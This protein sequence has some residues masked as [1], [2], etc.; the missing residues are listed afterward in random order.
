MDPP[1]MVLVPAELIS[2]ALVNLESVDLVEVDL[3]PEQKITFFKEILKT[4]VM[5]LK[6]L[7]SSFD[8]ATP[9]FI[10]AIVRVENVN[11]TSH[12]TLA[13][14]KSIF[15]EI[16]NSLE[17]KL[18]RLRLR[19]SNINRIKNDCPVLFSEVSLMVKI[20]DTL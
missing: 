11:L 9:S 16:R 14:L 10:R 6:N 3:Y 18:R 13:E 7:I 8:I 12:H 15:L 1:A 5:K 17:L 20:I 4:P 19:K 2:K